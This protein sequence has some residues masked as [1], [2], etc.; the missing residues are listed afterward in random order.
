VADT[1]LTVRRV[2]FEYPPGTDPAWNHRFREFAH[3]ANSI[4]LLMPYAEPYFIHSIRKA[5]PQL[6]DQLRATS[7]DFIKQ[8]AQHYKQHRVFNDLIGER[9]PAI[10]KLERLIGFT[11][12][13]LDRT[14]SLKFNLAFAAGS[15]TIAY[16][17][18]RWTEDHL[19]TMFDGADPV[20][21]TLY[22]WH[23]AEEV[24]HK[25]CAYDVFEAVDGSRLR[26]AA[27]K[28]LSFLLLALFCVS[29][30]TVM[31]WK[32][33]RLFHPV[34]IWRLVRWAFSL[35]FSVM[36]VMAASALPSHH[37]SVLT[38]PVYLRAWLAQYDPETETM[39]LWRSATP[40]QPTASP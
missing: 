22:L 24:E 30:V 9:Y 23:L 28:S 6:D 2:R 27:A 38:D 14:R 16:A 1:S 34:S 36:P 31:L 21:A 33:R 11:Y 4:S 35:C 25:S 18:A 3:G 10:P 37:P 39:P 20:P 5:L 12:G 26:Y 8:E 7:E 19:T 15:E 40:P 13:W 32:D 17:L 29:A